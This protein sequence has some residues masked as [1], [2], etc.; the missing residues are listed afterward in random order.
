MDAEY[1]PELVTLREPS[2]MRVQEKQQLLDFW[3]AR[4]D[5]ARI[6]HAFLWKAY[7]TPDGMVKYDYVE[8]DLPKE[9]RAGRKAKSKRGKQGRVKSKTSKGKRKAKA[10]TPPTSEEEPDDED[11]QGSSRDDGDISGSIRPVGREV[12]GRKVKKRSPSGKVPAVIP[13]V[14][15][16]EPASDNDLMTGRPTRGIQATVKPRTS[17]G[18]GKGKAVAL[19]TSEEE[20]LSENDQELLT[21]NEDRSSRGKGKEKAVTLQTSEEELDGPDA[22]ESLEH[23][24]NRSNLVKQVAQ[25]LK[26]GQVKK[27]SRSGK[28]AAVILQPSEDEL[29]SDDDLMTGIREEESLAPSA[30]VGEELED[31]STNKSQ[32]ESGEE[33]TKMPH[34]KPWQLTRAERQPKKPPIEVC[35]SG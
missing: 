10:V 8:E 29:A 1:I 4:Q 31:E 32:Q 34:L 18:K 9:S 13:Q 20:P 6:K 16:D 2:R 17:K 30:G 5:N 26:G 21:H 35:N 24:G 25:K 3:R 28:A 14:S 12:T 33:D 15:D 22:W 19:P 11:D 7:S 23:D 27:S